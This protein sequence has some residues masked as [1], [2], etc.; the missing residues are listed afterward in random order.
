ML[1]VDGSRAVV[2]VRQRTGVCCSCS[3]L[4]ACCLALPSTNPALLL[5]CPEGTSSM[6][7]WLAVGWQNTGA[8]CL[9]VFEGTSGI[10][11]TGTTLEFTGDVRLGKAEALWLC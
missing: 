5:L 10:D 7:L 4:P 8:V 2:Q 1:E 9:Q 3:A 6:N 11:N